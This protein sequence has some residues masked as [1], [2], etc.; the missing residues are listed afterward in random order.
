MTVAL[1]CGGRDFRPNGQA[2]QTA[3]VRK[4]NALHEARRFSLVI[5][6]GARGA[7][8]FGR[9]W[10]Y[11]AGIPTETYFA[12]WDRDGRAAGPIRNRRM[13]KD[14]KPDLVIAFPGGV[15]TADMIKAALAAGVEV[16]EL[17]KDTPND[18]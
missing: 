18:R 14:G 13:L 7:D 8:T 9:L 2:H 17:L 5:Q 11:G 12:N 4:L 10:A 16:I 15:G 3:I 6:G 1:I